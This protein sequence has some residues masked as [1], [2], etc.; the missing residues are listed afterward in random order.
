MWSVDEGRFSSVQAVPESYK[1]RDKKEDVM[2][3]TARRRHPAEET[4]SR[5]VLLFV[6]L[7]LAACI[8]IVHVPPFSISEIK[9]DCEYQKTYVTAPMPDGQIAVYIYHSPTGTLLETYIIWDNIYF[10]EKM[11]IDGCEP[12]D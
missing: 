6:S 11:R 5:A 1:E 4:M 10:R 9:Y 2:S 8:E 3:I 12:V 7:V